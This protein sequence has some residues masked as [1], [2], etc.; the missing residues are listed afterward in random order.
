MLISL[1]FMHM[2]ANPIYASLRSAV[3]N[4]GLFALAPDSPSSP[5]SS[6]LRAFASCAQTLKDRTSR[7]DASTG[8]TPSSSLFQEV[9]LG[10]GTRRLTFAT[11]TN[12]SS[13]KPLP[14][15]LKDACPEFAYAAATLRAT[16]DHAGQV[17]AQV[18]D[19]LVNVSASKSRQGIS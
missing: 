6:P 12:L 19:R 5:L 10:D 1:R 18:L 13:P 16:V 17:Y 14:E 11:S 8:A 3:F 4:T 2:Q 15:S 7:G 9:A